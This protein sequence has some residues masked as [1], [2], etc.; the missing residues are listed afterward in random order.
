[1]IGGLCLLFRGLVLRSF[2][3]GL[4]LGFLGRALLLALSPALGGAFAGTLVPPL[5]VEQAVGAGQVRARVV[6]I[7]P[8]LDLDE[9]DLFEADCGSVHGLHGPADAGGQAPAG[10]HVLVGVFGG[11]A[12]GRVC[13]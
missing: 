7:A 11:V 3:L 12:F 4:L 1:G 10:G 2:P 9:A 6:G 8:T 5:A 13:V